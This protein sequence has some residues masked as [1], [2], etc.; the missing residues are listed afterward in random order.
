MLGNFQRDGQVEG[1]LYVQWLFQVV[2]LKS[3]KGDLQPVSIDVVTVHSVNVCRTVFFKHPQPGPL[4]TADID[5]AP[6][7]NEVEHKRHHRTRR[8]A[9]PLTTLGE[10]IARIR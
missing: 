7:W 9:S 2:R 6:H 4:S 3:L 10:K 1:A 8:M 5:H